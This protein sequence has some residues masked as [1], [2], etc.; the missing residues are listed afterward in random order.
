[1]G[2]KVVYSDVGKR[3]KNSGD[4]GF[5]LRTLIAVALLLFA[6]TVRLTWQEGTTRLRQVLIP[7]ELRGAEAAFSEMVRDIQEGTQLNDAFRTFCTEILNE[8][9]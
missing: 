6:L 1:M 8:D 7:G 3:K 9:T 2:Y 5:R 4:S